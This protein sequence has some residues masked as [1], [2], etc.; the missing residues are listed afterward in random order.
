M[1]RLLLNDARILISILL[2]RLRVDCSMRA[3]E[4]LELIMRLMLLWNCLVL[5][6]T[7][8]S[9]HWIIEINLVLVYALNWILLLLLVGVWLAVLL[10]LLLR[11]IERVGTSWRCDYGLW[12][13]VSILNANLDWLDSVSS[14]VWSV[15]KNSPSQKQI[16][17]L[18]KF[19]DML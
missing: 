12:L 14:W 15:L 9:R 16:V 10:L 6:L 13:V 4:R 5:V 3:V 17:L 2:K 1:L 11:L 18:Q 8:W 19:K 7:H